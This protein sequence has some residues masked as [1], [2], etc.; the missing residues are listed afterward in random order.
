MKSSIDLESRLG[1]V[2]ARKLLTEFLAKNPNFFSYGSYF[3]GRMAERKLIMSDVI[4]VLHKGHIL[5]DA[6]WENGQWRYRVE[7]DRII[8]VIAF[9]NPSHIRGVTCWRKDE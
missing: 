1:K 4:N 9:A 2:Q 8:V 7:T 3:K 5:K 6:E